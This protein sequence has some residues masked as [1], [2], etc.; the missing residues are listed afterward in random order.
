MTSNW[1]IIIVVGA[2]GS[3]GSLSNDDEDGN[4]NSAKPPAIG[5]M[6]KNSPSARAYF[7]NFHFLS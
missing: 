5:L 7:A 1:S 6:S 2:A 4:D 3:I